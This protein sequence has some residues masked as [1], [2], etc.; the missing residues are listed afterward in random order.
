MQGVKFQSVKD[1]INFVG[2]Y[3]YGELG[4]LVKNIDSYYNGESNGK[5]NGK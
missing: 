5:E 2:P 3:F 4:T 1:E